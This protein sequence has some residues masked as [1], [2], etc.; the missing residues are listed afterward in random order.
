MVLSAALALAETAV[1]AQE[2][3]P[4]F[5]AGKIRVLIFSG[6]NNTSMAM[7]VAA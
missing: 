4:L 2:S 5:Q 6:R 3:L 1:F 7:V